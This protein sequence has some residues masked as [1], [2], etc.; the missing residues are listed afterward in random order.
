MEA[1]AEDAEDVEEVISDG[2]EEEE[3]DEDDDDGQLAEEDDDEDDGEPRDFARLVKDIF[4]NPSELCVTPLGFKSE[5][6][7]KQRAH[8]AILAEFIQAESFPFKTV[9]IT[10][11]D[12]DVPPL[13]VHIIHHVHML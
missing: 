5:S 10:N 2:N 11:C 1:K 12:I 9:C 6:D 13:Q 4:R 7:F 8:D 3:E